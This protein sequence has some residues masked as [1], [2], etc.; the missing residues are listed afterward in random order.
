MIDTLGGL[1]RKMWVRFLLAGL[2]LL[3]PLAVAVGQSPPAVLGTWT[4]K[5]AQNKGSTGYTV[6]M[7]ISANAAETDY[8]ELKC[9]G[10]LTRVGAANGYVFFTE[11]ITRGGKSSGGNCIDGTITVTPASDKLIWGWIGGF[12]NETFVA[13]GTLVRK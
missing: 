1:M 6:V 3:P 8:P 9:G 12:N 7:T 11:T 10:K 13:W 2:F 5:V 4:G